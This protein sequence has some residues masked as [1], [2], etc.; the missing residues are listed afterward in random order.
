LDIPISHVIGTIALIMLTTSVAAYFAI[1]AY[2]LQSDILRQHLIEVSSYVSTNLMEIVALINFADFASND[3][4][5]KVLKM[6]PDISGYPYAIELINEGGKVLVRSYLIS[7]QDIMV[8]IKMPL[9]AEANIKILTI[10]D[11]KIILHAGGSGRIESA[12]RVYSGW[13]GIVVWSWGGSQPIQAGI[14]I[15][16]G[17]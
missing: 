16:R 2:H 3:T 11:G 9:R 13:D 17:G 8:S 7:R 15:L 12:G 1:T 4:M 5:F 14:G 6:P 10:D